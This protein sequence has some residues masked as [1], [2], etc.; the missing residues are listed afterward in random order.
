LNFSKNDISQS[1]S[2]LSESGQ[3]LCGKLDDRWIGGWCQANIA[4]KVAEPR[5]SETEQKSQNKLFKLTQFS[6]IQNSNSS[7]ANFKGFF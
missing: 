7:I 5:N 2:D 1:R 6:D 4:E 3:S